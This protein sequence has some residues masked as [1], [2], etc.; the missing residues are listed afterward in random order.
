M[1]TE[2]KK[3]LVINSNFMPGKVV[4]HIRLRKSLTPI[5]ADPAICQNSS[6]ARLTPMKNKLIIADL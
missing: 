3:K 5:R 4:P 1:K 2:L 6:K